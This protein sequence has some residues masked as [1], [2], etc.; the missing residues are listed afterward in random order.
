MKLSFQPRLVWIL[1]CLG[2]FTP[3]CHAAVLPTQTDTSVA[4]HSDDAA[5]QA[6]SN[7]VLQS[8]GLS[9]WRGIQSAEESVTSVSADKGADEIHLFWDDWSTE[10]TRYRRR[11]VGQKEI[12]RNHSGQATFKA[13]PA[14]PRSVV[15]EF[16]QAR[17]LVT[18]LPA[19]AAELMLQRANYVLKLSA[20]PQCGDGMTCIDIFR[21]NKPNELGSLEQKW[22]INAKTGLPD[23]V[24]FKLQT[25]NHYVEA[26]WGEVDYLRYTSTQGV[27]VPT[28]TQTIQL[29]IKRMWSFRSLALNPI[30]NTATFD[31]EVPNEAR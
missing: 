1:V 12:P 10:S 4:P 23:R 11:V 30:F 3:H 5:I 20:S 17:A 7:V 25:S 15:A 16:D 29:G 28:T 13:V 18:R 27:I 31:A 8:G 21:S 24:R 22:W 9:A 6:M 19:A 2:I 26:P 14:D